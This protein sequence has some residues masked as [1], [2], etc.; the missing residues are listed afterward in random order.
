MA[1]CKNASPISTQLCV[2]LTQIQRLWLVSVVHLCLAAPIHKSWIYSYRPELLKSKHWLKFVNNNGWWSLTAVKLTVTCRTVQWR[3][4]VSLSRLSPVLTQ[5]VV[6]TFI[7]PVYSWVCQQ[8]P[9]YLLP[10]SVFLMNCVFLSSQYQFTVAR[11]SLMSLF[12]R[13]VTVT[14][15]WCHWVTSSLWGA[16]CSGLDLHCL[17]LWHPLLTHRY[18]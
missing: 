9:A 7:I 15:P 3:P 12:R 16:R 13:D 5:Y 18:S 10:I 17:T 11:R 2:T 8:G 1:D 4:L 6:F 14:S